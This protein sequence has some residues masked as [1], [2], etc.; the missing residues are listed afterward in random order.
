MRAPSKNNKFMATI[1]FAGGCFWGTEHFMKQIYG[2]TDTE[3]GYANSVVENPS[4][5]EVK[6]G[7]TQAVET[8]KVVY[9][10][11]VVD[12]RFLLN[13]FFLTIDPT[14]K[15]RQ[16]N[17][18]GTQYR[19]GIYYTT[20]EQHKVI[21]AAL[22]QLQKGYDAPIVTEVMPIGN[23]YSAEEYHQDYLDKNP[24]GYCHVNPKLFALAREM[25]RKG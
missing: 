10:E 20:E 5:G 13:L 12:L 14:I 21:E 4:Y 3:V 8:V 11:A 17:D 2:V 1:Y 18:V 22:A 6:T 23:F 15:N 24:G 9:D 19:T 7:E 16:G 25:S